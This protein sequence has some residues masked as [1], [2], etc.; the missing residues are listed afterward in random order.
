M[1]VVTKTVMIGLW[2]FVSMILMIEMLIVQ[3]YLFNNILLLLLIN[4]YYNLNMSYH[5]TKMVINMRSNSTSRFEVI[6]KPLLPI[7]VPMCSQVLCFEV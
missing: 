4:Y 6:D 5:L 2:C 1:I 3:N 7:Q